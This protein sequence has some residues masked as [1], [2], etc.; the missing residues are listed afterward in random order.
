MTDATQAE[1]P[2]HVEPELPPPAN[3]IAAIARVTAEI[4]GIRKLTPTQRAQRGM[5]GGDEKGVTWAYRGIDQIA[6]AAQP[7]FGKYGIVVMPNVLAHETT[8]IIKGQNVTL[9]TTSWYRQQVTVEWTVYG[10]GGVTDFIRCETVGVGD[11]NSD[12]GMNK[13]MTAAFKNLLL[14]LLCIGD[15]L[16]DTD[17]YG[18]GGDVHDRSTPSAALEAAGTIACTP[19]QWADAWSKAKPKDKTAVTQYAAKTLGLRNITNPSDT[20]AGTLAWVLANVQAG[21]EPGAGPVVA[22]F[23]PDDKVESESDRVGTP[24]SDETGQPEVT[25]PPPDP[26]AEPAKATSRGKAARPNKPLDGHEHDHGPEG[27]AECSLCGIE[28]P[29]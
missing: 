3:V 14:R 25:D 10:P 9:E 12:K 20:E 1:A 27:L 15:P 2:E 19:D 22:S 16:D 28:A 6:Q 13:A 5:S 4:G 24:D 17:N 29:F 11:D 26:P 21:R 23:D 8:K 18:P 7:L